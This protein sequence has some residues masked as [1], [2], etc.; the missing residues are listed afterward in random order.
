[1][2]DEVSNCW[3]V[4]SRDPWYFRVAE[5]YLISQPTRPNWW[6]RLWQRLLLGWKWEAQDE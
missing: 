3:A 6:F 1:M 2:S 5:H 4:C